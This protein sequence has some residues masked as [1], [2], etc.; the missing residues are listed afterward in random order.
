MEAAEAKVQR[1]LEGSRQFLVPHYQRPYS[2]AEQQ[3]KTL[4]NDLVE[5]MEDP[6]PKPHFLGS[7]VT[8]PARSVPEGVEKRLLIDGQQRLTTILILLMVIRDRARETGALRLAERADDLIK[9]RHEDG[10]DSFKLLPTQGEDPTDSDRDIFTKL[11]RGETVAG[12]KGIAAAYRY[13]GGHLRRDDAPDIDSLFRIIVVNLTLVSIILDEKDNAHRIFESLNGTGRP[14]SQVDLIRNYFFMRIDSREHDYVYRDLWRPMQRQLGEDALQ[15]FVRHYLMRS[16]ST[17]READVYVALKLRIDEDAARTPLDHLKDLVRFA[18]YYDA[19]LHPEKVSSPDVRQR[20]ERLNRLEMTVAYPFLLSVLADH[21]EGVRDE[22]VVCAAFDAVE[23]YLIRRFVCGV[24]SH[25]LNKMF[26]SLYDQASRGAD[27]VET[28]HRTLSSNARH[29][30]RDKE[31]GELLASARLY[32]VGERRQ[33]TKLILERLE[34]NAGHKETVA[35]GALT[36]EHVMPQTLNDAWKAELGAAWEDEHDQLLHTL[37][38]L[39]LTS[40]NAE[41][42]NTTFSEKCPRFLES[43]LELNRY[44]GTVQQWN[45][46][47]IQRR[48]RLLIQQALDI[49]P[50]FGPKPRGLADNHLP[51]EQAADAPVITGTTPRLLRMAG[52]DI[53]VQSWVDVWVATM[54]G[55]LK[56]GEE[57]FRQVIEEIPKVVSFEV[58]D[59][60]RGSRS[61][62]LSN[63]AHLSTNLSAASIY[64]RCLQ[65]LRV[66]GVA[67]DDWLVVH[68]RQNRGDSGAT[69]S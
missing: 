18:G 68:D 39:T 32:G 30:P 20:L 66:A 15:D 13:F 56:L 40:Y 8:S 61:R 63:G 2:W 26:P 34:A 3:W 25:G 48:A 14:L 23:N 17:I 57:E 6:S 58:A 1:V 29:Y 33:K 65:A 69:G 54:E 44:F 47:E 38:N 51:I 28:L 49:W 43:H 24:P 7:I 37:G 64:R 31:F 12:K 9:N 62:R 21:A 67:Q 55:I 35:F 36:I 60:R 45:A 22:S 50:Y 53:E 19:L 27:F 46:D 11:V 41:L 10:N 52:K 59:L 16:G 5:L 42:G 4:W